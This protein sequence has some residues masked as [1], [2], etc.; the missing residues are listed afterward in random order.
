MELKEALEKLRL[1]NKFKD[2]NQKNKDNF[3]SYALKIVDQNNEKPWQLG[4]Y[5]KK[6]DKIA[7][8]IIDETIELI[9]EEDIFKKPGV[10]IN[11]INMEKIKLPFD[12][13]ITKAK[14]FQKEKY[15]NELLN[16]T[17]ALLQ[18]LEKYGTVW[19]LTFLTKAFKTLNMK[20]NP[21]TGEIIDH[22]LDSLMDFV[23]K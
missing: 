9:G 8:F 13:I 22:K 5:H 18:R 7:T 21:E 16:K 19:N 4:F 10:E 6:N 11:P 14:E 1:D 23:E 15:P 17:I 20:I 2:W 3:F 12:E